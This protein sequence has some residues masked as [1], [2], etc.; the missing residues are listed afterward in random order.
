M[1]SD[2]IEYYQKGVILKIP[3]SNNSENFL[4]IDTHIVQSIL[5]LEILNWLILF[6]SLLVFRINYI[7]IQS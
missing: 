4:K 7:K 2:N 1:P 6:T 5:L 3:A